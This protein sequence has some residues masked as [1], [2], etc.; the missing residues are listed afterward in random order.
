MLQSQG[1]SVGTSR[2]EER[3]S[4]D[5]PCDAT[6]DL[7]FEVRDTIF[8]RMEG[9][10]ATAIK[11]AS[12]LLTR[13]IIYSW[14]TIDFKSSD[15]GDLFLTSSFQSK[16]YCPVLAPNS[17][18]TAL[19]SSFNSFPP[20]SLLFKLLRAATFYRPHTNL[21]NTPTLSQA[22]VFIIITIVTISNFKSETQF[23]MHTVSLN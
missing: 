8:K 3:V 10:S 4:P 17:I 7:V 2:S 1:L 16:L 20:L 9:H 15:M 5:T 19:S 6:L 13:T 23:K 14:H 22:R 18:H 11:D 12:K 21:I